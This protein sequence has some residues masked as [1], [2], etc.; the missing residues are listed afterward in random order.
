MLVQQ[1][2]APP[3]IG[4]DV[5]GAACLQFMALSQFRNLQNSGVKN[6]VLLLDGSQ[7]L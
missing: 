2:L 6:R 5:S 3:Q 4:N 7:I 1:R